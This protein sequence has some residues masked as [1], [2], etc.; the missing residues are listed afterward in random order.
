LVRQVAQEWHAI[1]PNKTLKFKGAGFYEFGFFINGVSAQDLD[2]AELALV[3]KWY[4][5]TSDKYDLEIEDFTIA[6]KR[7]RR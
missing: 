5:N 7:R 4:I 6:P 2:E 1:H 3:T